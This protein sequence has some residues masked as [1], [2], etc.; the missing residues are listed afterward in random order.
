ML[1]YSTLTNFVLLILSQIIIFKILKFKKKWHLISTFVFIIIFFLLNNKDIKSIE[2]LNY[3]IFN[4]TILICYIIFLTLIFN[5]SPTLFYLENSDLSKF[6][7]RGFVKDRLNLMISDNLINK[8]MKITP[9]GINLL[10]I[11][12]LLSNI[13]FKEND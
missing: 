3:L 12:N 9:K 8:D 11:S 2:F 7:E 1:L 6:K 10:K 13:F 5:E 4:S